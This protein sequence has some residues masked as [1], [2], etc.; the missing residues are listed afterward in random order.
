[1]TKKQQ[2]NKQQRE[3][4]KDDQIE[5]NFSNYLQHIS[6]QSF[7]MTTLGVKLLQSF[8]KC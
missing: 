3:R 1:M 6:D 8:S 5:Q 7:C 4:E 2:T